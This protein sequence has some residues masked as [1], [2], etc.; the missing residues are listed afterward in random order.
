MISYIE[1]V[2]SYII[3]YDMTALDIMTKYNRLK[4]ALNK[5]KKVTQING[6]ECV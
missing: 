2:I 6:F 4:I 5:N 3:L 1:I